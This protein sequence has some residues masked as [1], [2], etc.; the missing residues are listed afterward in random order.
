MLTQAKIRKGLK[1]G[2]HFDGGGLH[3]R[4]TS[5]GSAVW[6]LRITIKEV[7]K[8]IQLGDS[9]ALTLVEARKLAKAERDRIKKAGDFNAAPL[10]KR[11]K[12]PKAEPVEQSM[13]TF[14]W[15]A[16]QYI[17]DHEPGWSKS[18]AVAWKHTL[19]AYAYPHI[20]ELPVDKITVDHMKAVVKPIWTEKTE[21]ANRVL[22]RCR[23][24]LA[25]AKAS[26]YRD[27]DNPAAWKDNMSMFL[28]DRNK[29]APVQHHEALP[30]REMPAFMAKLRA[31]DDYAARALIFTILT[32]AR[33][34]EA[35]GAAWGE[36]DLAAAE[37]TIPA[38][39]MKAGKEH[40]VPLSP[41]LV[42]VIGERPAHAAA[43]DVVF[44]GIRTGGKNGKQISHM[45]FPRLM[46]LLGYPTLTTHGFRS[47][48][49]DWA[50]ETTDYANE[51]VEMALAHAIG[52]KVEAAYR[53]GNLLEK[54]RAL[55]ND[56]TSYCFSA[57]VNA[58]S[59][60]D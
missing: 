24:V 25:W 30:F 12:K 51:V 6:V 58:Q 39:R 50:A 56:W 8:D 42:S 27:G 7:T 16:D 19:S 33:S 49:R 23:I 52:S 14:K 13:P 10:P 54:R 57:T 47:T 1:A 60:P 3:L 22:S 35:R 5:G 11:E 44:P 34:G 37:W 21:T 4:V 40:R 28:A 31:S 17:A 29:V 36:I 18:N 45:S 41:Q 32:A 59:Q 43:K 55:M 38:S 20:G 9:L 48:F 26:K 46:A 15:C 2:R 53:R